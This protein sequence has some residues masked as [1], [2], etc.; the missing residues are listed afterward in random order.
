MKYLINNHSFASLVTVQQET[1][2]VHVYQD[3]VWDAKSYRAEIFK[4]YNDEYTLVDVY[5]RH[6]LHVEHF[7]A[8]TFSGAEKRYKALLSMAEEII[9]T[10]LEMENCIEDDDFDFL[11]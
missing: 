2:V 11:F 8:T 6:N 3:S 4:A 9:K 10:A 1:Y 5:G 7:Y